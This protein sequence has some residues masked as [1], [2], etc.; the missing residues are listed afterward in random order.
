M[1][2]ILIATDFS[3]ASRNA[4]LYGMQLAKA[5]QAHVILFNAFQ[6][7]VPLPDAMVMVSPSEVQQTVEDFLR[8]EAKAINPGNEV[9][10]ET[11]CQ[12]DIPVP[13]ILEKAM[14]IKADLI[15][16]GMKGIGKGF[17]KV[18]GSSTI[19]LMRKTT[20]PVMAIPEE[21]AYTVPR[22]IVFATAKDDV[23]DAQAPSLHFLSRF[24]A[25][26]ESKIFAVHV[27]KEG[28]SVVTQP[29]GPAR[30]F[31]T[32]FQTIPLQYEYPI[33]Q[34]IAHALNESISSHKAHILAMIPHKH[35]LLDRLF[36]KSETKQMLF[37]SSVPVLVLPELPITAG[38]SK[39][40][41]P[42][43]KAVF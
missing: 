33:D 25:K 13:S 2:K 31:E 32:I 18:F 35:E 30:G 8:E 38:H 14:E 43:L 3:N 9:S 11:I 29:S 23:N 36:N 4:S 17:R 27:V 16:V 28:E 37:Q 12:N 20:I 15:I 24:A 26:F 7:P 21:A 5:Y 22:T 19:G 10:L 34:N 39:P 1:K 41:W 42:D 6:V 40:E